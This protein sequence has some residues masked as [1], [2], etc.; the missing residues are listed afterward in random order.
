MRNALT[1]MLLMGSTALLGLGIGGIA[2]DWASTKLMLGAAGVLA[3]AA[4]AVVA[5]GE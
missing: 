2:H 4:M 3:I 5:S 1:I